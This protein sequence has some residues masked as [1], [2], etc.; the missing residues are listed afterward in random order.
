MLPLEGDKV[1]SDLMDLNAVIKSEVQKNGLSWRAS[2]AKNTDARWYAFIDVLL[3]TI[4]ELKASNEFDEDSIY[5]EGVHYLSTFVPK[6][7]QGIARYSRAHFAE[8]LSRHL[9][10][11]IKNTKPP[12]HLKSLEEA[13]NQNDDAAFYHDYNKAYDL[14]DL[15]EIII[16][17]IARLG[18]RG[19]HE[20]PTKRVRQS[21]RQ[22]H[23]AERY[24][25]KRDALSHMLGIAGYDEQSI[26]E[27]AT[28]SGVVEATIRSRYFRAIEALQD[29]NTAIDLLL[30]YRDFQSTDDSGLIYTHDALAGIASLT[31]QEAPKEEA[32][33]QVK[34]VIERLEDKV[35]KEKAEV[36]YRLFAG[37]PAGFIEFMR[38]NYEI[39][40]GARELRKVIRLS[41]K[42][43]KNLKPVIT[44]DKQEIIIEDPFVNNIVDQ[45]APEEKKHYE[46]VVLPRLIESIMP[47]FVRDP[48]KT[49]ETLN[50]RAPQNKLFERIAHY[51]EDVQNLQVQGLKTALRPYQKADILFMEGNPRVLYANDM[52]LGKSLTILSAF[53]RSGA[54]KMLIIGPSS[55]T[56]GV[57]PQEITKHFENPPK[58]AV[59]DSGKAAQHAGESLHNADIMIVNYNI[60]S[61]HPERFRDLPFDWIVVDESHMVTNEDTQRY[62]A[63]AQL[64]AFRKVQSSGT[65]FRNTRRELWSPL[66]WLSP[67]RFGLSWDEY[68]ERY[69]TDEGVYALAY[70][71]KNIMIRRRKSEMLPE[72][73][74][75]TM[76][77]V[78][79]VLT[80]EERRTYQRMENDFSTWWKNEV[81]GRQSVSNILRGIVM[82][83]L[84]ALRMYAIQP[85]LREIPGMIEDIRSRGEKV[86]IS[87]TYRA[88]AKD[89]KL[90][91]QPHEV[92]YIDGAVKGEDRAK[93]ID[94]FQTSPY[95]IAMIITEAGSQSITLTAAN[96]MI[97][98]NDPWT[99]AAKQQGIDRLHRL[100]QT[101]PVNVYNLMA[102]KTVDGEIRKLIEDKGQEL[103]LV[104]NNNTEYLAYRKDEMKDIHSLVM[105]LVS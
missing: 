50:K 76:A 47:V 94:D 11:H 75:V 10:I 4:A 33:E 101:R 51:F 6:G 67:E 22:S 41:E 90:L 36:I 34:A 97:V 26:E 72:L 66:R 25:N 85:K 71:L 81:K 74:P 102:E 98:V 86:V 59:I 32:T 45:L 55:A 58:Y 92:A 39:S 5:S 63:L 57:W 61:R 17:V 53:K 7:P 14:Q 35:G 87:T 103:S 8:H 19:A 62:Q 93:E 23:I 56:S 54:E 77:D 100:G 84:H 15:K 24:Q 49:I 83:K 18:G 30:P 78:S 20:R 89:I 13:V 80:S 82:S 31:E 37:N 40:P 60:L 48:I 95:K 9:K 29:D 65:P 38:Q 28:R 64:H 44:T 43:C 3:D 68:R 69:M 16:D 91:F 88:P 12:V 105:K 79:V 73:P 104:L 1:E 2:M 70:D 52:G 46:D 96:N 27:L 42:E 21:E 99:W